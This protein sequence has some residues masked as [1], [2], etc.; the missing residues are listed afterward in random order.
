MNKKLDWS[1]IANKDY[2]NHLYHA[3]GLSLVQM[4]NILGVNASLIRRQMIKLGISRRPA[5]RICR[6]T[7]L[8]A[9]IMS[10]PGWEKMRW[11][12]LAT[13]FGCSTSAINRC[14]TTYNKQLE[15]QSITD[16]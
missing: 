7:S 4:E 10:L 9:R 12:E 13:K 16:R 5:K 14:K 3:Q 2:L 1:M 8:H 6:S 11:K 15:K